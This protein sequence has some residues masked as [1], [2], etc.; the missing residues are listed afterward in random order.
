LTSE[1]RQ[2]TEENE[3]RQFLFKAFNAISLAI[4]LAFVICREKIKETDNDA[5]SH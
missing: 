5:L 1:P 4:N 2:R 3:I